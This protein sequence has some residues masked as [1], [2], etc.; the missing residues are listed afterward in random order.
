[1]IVVKSKF[2][3]FKELIVLYTDS[4]EDI[5]FVGYPFKG[6]CFDNQN[7]QKS[8]LCDNYFGYSSFIQTNLKGANFKNS[9]LIKCNFEGADLTDV[10]FEGANLKGVNFR[11][12][13]FSKTIF[14]SYHNM[15]LEGT[16]T[17][18]DQEL[19]EFITRTNILKNIKL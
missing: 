9:C 19:E 6:A 14:S 4:L 11:G 13:K 1:M 18:K 15:N 16:I 3:P 8:L 10:N 7:M 2:F 12:A 5:N 17:T